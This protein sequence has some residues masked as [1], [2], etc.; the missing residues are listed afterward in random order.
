MH[1]ANFPATVGLHLSQISAARLFLH[2]LVGN[3][4]AV[5][6]MVAFLGRFTFG[7]FLRSVSRNEGTHREGDKRQR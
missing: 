4:L 6:H 1:P 2:F 5:N 3:A 7:H